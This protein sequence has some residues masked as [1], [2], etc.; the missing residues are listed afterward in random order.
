MSQILL[1]NYFRSSTSYRARLALHHKNIPFEYKAISLLKG[2]QRSEEYLKLNPMGGVPTL[3]HD[4]HVIAESFAI[5]EYI[6]EVF[7]QNPLLPKDVVKRAQ[8]RQ[9]CEFV[10]ADIHPL[11][12]LKIQKYLS[13]NGFTDTQKEAWLQHWFGTGLAALEK[14]LTKYAGKYC[15]GD[16]ITLADIFMVPQYMSAA[17]FGLDMSKF[18]LLTK[19]NDNCLQ[20]E[21]FKKSH[22]FRQIDTPDDLRIP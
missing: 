12:N 1:Y 21:T 9:A 7:P 11:G 8:I 17:R 5:I 3:V 2:E 13:E 16:E 10:N 4:G 15:F 14:L 19:I 6:E 18:K 22:P 20:L